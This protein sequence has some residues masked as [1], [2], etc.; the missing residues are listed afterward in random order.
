MACFQGCFAGL[1]RERDASEGAAHVSEVLPPALRILTAND[2]YRSSVLG[3]NPRAGCWVGWVWMVRM[4][5]WWG[6]L[7]VWLFGL[8]GQHWPTWCDLVIPRWAVLVKRYGQRHPFCTCASFG[9]ALLCLWLWIWGMLRSIF[10]ERQI[11]RYSSRLID[12][13]FCVDSCKRETTFHLGSRYVEFLGETVDGWWLSGSPIAT[14][15]YHSIW[16]TC[17]LSRWQTGYP[18]VTSG[19]IPGSTPLRSSI[20]QHVINPLSCA[21][22]CAC[23]LHQVLA[24]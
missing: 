10:K 9:D 20:N 21:N 13:C 14:G 17:V 1:R 23:H 2:I 8:F 6:C 12:I 11:D 5:G 16:K 4:L 24:T 3:G 19:H 7:V 22:G 18:I 15:F